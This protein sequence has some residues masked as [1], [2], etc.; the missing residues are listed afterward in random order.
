MKNSFSLLAMILFFGSA[1]AQSIDRQVISNGG[2]FAS[3]ATAQISSTLGEVSSKYLTTSNVLLSQGF[4]QGN[5]SIVSV[6]NLLAK[7]FKILVYPNPFVDFIEISSEEN[8]NEVA[9]ELIDASGKT[10]SLSQ[11][12]LK[13]GFQW[14]LSTT[15]LPVGNYWLIIH[16]FGNQSTIPLSHLKN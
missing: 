9:F 7:E 16:A 8:T 11:E 2:S 1:F 14:K 4:Q 12:I 10:T 15:N 6:K 3:T 13:P 5:L